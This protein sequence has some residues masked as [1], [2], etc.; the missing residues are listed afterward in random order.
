MQK[1]CG[2][3]EY[4]QLTAADSSLI[5]KWI[6]NKIGASAVTAQRLNRTTNKCEASH[7]T[8]LKSLPKSR[9]Y[10]RNFKGRANSACHSLSIGKTKSVIVANRFLK[11]KNTSSGRAHIAR[12]KILQRDK[13]HIQRKKSKAYKASQKR[14]R[15][16][17][18]RCR[19]N[20]STRSTSYSTGCQDPVVQGDH[21]YDMP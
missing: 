8:V 10:R 7:L 13:Y 5:S 17:S 16:L 1:P 11:A 15:V 6:D 12:M 18:K 20:P 2:L 4:V 19:I 9:N 3:K 21:A 14:H